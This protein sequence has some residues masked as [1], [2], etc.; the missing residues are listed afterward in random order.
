MMQTKLITNFNS[1]ASKSLVIVSHSLDEAITRCVINN[2]KN[3]G[4]DVTTVSLHELM[5]EYEICDEIR[6]TG[7]CV[8]WI[9]GFEMPISNTNAFLLNRV[10]YVPSI[11]FSGFAK[12]DREYA[13]REFEA[14]M[15]YSF[16]AFSG[17]GNHLANGACV[18]SISLPRQWK[19]VA[20][21]FAI[22]IPNY[23]WGPYGFNHLNNKENLVHSTIYNFLH[24]S[25]G[26][27]PKENSHVFCF[28]KPQGKPVFIFSIGNEQLI[29]SDI[30]LSIELREKLKILAGKINK[31]FNHFISE[32]LIFIDG[33]DLNFGCINPEIIRSSKNKEFE[34]F[35]CRNLVKEFYN[36]LN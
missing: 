13:Q 19:N 27:K 8:K 4:V 29:T 9:K 32:I 16:N 17:I 15:G 34:G 22:N 20:K 3:L 36:C 2:K 7:T 24:W 12:K 11:L 35:V 5:T 14:Y 6:D 33:A 25:I 28:E 26:S 18:D 30:N 23:Y 21:E 31:F 10:L 1:A